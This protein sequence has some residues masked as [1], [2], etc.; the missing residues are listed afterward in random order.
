MKRIVDNDKRLREFT[1]ERRFF[2]NQDEWEWFLFQIVGD[3]AE[4]AAKYD[5]VDIEAI[6]NTVE[7]PDEYH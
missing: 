3:G 7:F 5:T 4:L 1:M 6:F 2:R